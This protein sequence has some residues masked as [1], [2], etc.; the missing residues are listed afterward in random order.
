MQVCSHIVQAIKKEA[1][2]AREVWDKGAGS[3]P[4]NYCFEMLSMV[5]ALSGSPVGR[6]HLAHQ[7]HLLKHLLALLHTGSARVQRQVVS[8]FRRILA[9]ITPTTLAQVLGVNELP[10]LDLTALQLPSSQEEIVPFDMHR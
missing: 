4:D 10:D 5:L 2:R 3:H 8:L 7:E 6:A 9:D 1:K